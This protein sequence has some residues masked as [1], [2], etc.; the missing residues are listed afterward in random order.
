MAHT[1]R[2]TGGGFTFKSCPSARLGNLKVLPKRTFRTVVKDWVEVVA[3]RRYVAF[4][5]DEVAILL[6]SS[7]PTF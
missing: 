3:Q 5:M 4:Q 2:R 6:K 7:S 1:P